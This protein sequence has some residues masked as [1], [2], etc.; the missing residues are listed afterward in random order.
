MRDTPSV[1]TDNSSIPEGVD[2]VLSDSPERDSPERDSPERDSPE[3]D[4]PERDSAERDSAERDSADVD[5]V[6]RIGSCQLYCINYNRSSR[7]LPLSRFLR[8]SFIKRS[9][10]LPGARGCQAWLGSWVNPCCGWNSA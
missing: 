6:N 7:F 8:L 3:R 5:R 2:P 1:E 4:S 9:S 10:P